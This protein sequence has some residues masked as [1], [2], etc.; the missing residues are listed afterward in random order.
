MKVLII[1]ALVNL[2]GCAFGTESGIGLAISK[3]VNHMNISSNL[4]IVKFK[5]KSTT[6]DIISSEILKRSENNSIAFEVFDLVPNQKTGFE[7][8]ATAILLFERTSSLMDFYNSMKFKAT[9]VDFINILAYCERIDSE[10][11]VRAEAIHFNLLLMYVDNRDI[12]LAT[13]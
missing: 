5:E 2:I 12:L 11:G 7:L 4:R 1:F 13:T 3:I 6:I 8:N 9:N 10:W